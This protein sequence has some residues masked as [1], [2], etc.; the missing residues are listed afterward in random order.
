MPSS[1][2][3]IP[4]PRTTAALSGVSAVPVAAHDELTGS[5]SENGAVL[6]T[7]PEQ[8][9]LRF[10]GEPMDL[11]SQ[12]QVT[13]FTGT[14]V[15]E[16]NL[17]ING[18]QV[19]QPLTDTGTEEKT[20]QV[21]W[22]VVSSD[23]HLLEVPARAR[24]PAHGPTGMCCYAERAGTAMSGRSRGIRRTKTTMPTSSTKV[25]VTTTSGVRASE[26][27]NA[28]ARGSTTREL[29]VAPLNT[30]ARDAPGPRPATR[31]ATIPIGTITTKKA[32]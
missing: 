25:W 26:A 7:A 29:R 4:L 17:E 28:R 3:R 11:G 6:G 10:S 9:Q 2:P 12:I 32:T 1:D 21:I 13:D 24:G 23:G 18:T 8:I 15:T 20:Y 22:R 16:G 27:G 30:S 5:T 14:S 19:V 31:A